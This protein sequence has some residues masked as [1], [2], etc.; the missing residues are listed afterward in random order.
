VVAN[1][2]KKR[3]IFAP[4]KINLFLHV[5]GKRSD[6]YHDL[7]SLVVFADIGDEIIIE[8]SVDFE[9]NVKGPFAGHFK[10]TERDCS[11]NSANLAVQAFW[12]MAGAARKKPEIKITLTKN[13]PLS[14]GLG[15]GSANAAAV[16]W[17]L[18]D[19]WQ[20]PRHLPF[21]EE[22]ASELGADV[23][24]C[25]DCR[26]VKMTGKGEIVEPVNDMP[27]IPVMLV[28]PGKE[29]KTCTVFSLF[30]G[31]FKNKTD[32]PESFGSLD[33]LVSFL[34]NCENSLVRTSIEAVSEI[35]DILEE[36]KTF[37][38]NTLSRMCGS[39]PT[40]YSLFED[41]EKACVSADSL[42]KRHPSW[43]IRTG[44]INRP[45]RY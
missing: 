32:I 37:K 33:D 23:P 12:K 10:V 9:F 19:L 34:E 11:P 22:L 1:S 41:I 26:P 15:G 27:E 8:P 43:W 39:G 35:G 21:V 13:L 14:S 30:P 5:T 2:E 3:T 36:L 42:R 29:C 38:G 24:A 20:I 16:I 18:L 17:G 7:D 28:N 40:C 6:G 45:Q 4:A 25:I 44:W 31:P